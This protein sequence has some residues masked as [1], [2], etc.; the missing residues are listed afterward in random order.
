[1][2]TYSRNSVDFVGIPV[3]LQVL[4]FIESNGGKLFQKIGETTF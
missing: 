3:N 4:Y 1:M 2:R